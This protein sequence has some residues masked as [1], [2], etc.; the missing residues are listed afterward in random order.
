M[1]LPVASLIQDRRQ[2]DEL[3]NA[4]LNRR[5]QLIQF[6]R[7]LSLRQDYWANMYTLLDVLQQSK[8]LGVARRFVSNEPRTGFDAALSI[9]TRNPIPWRIPLLGSDEENQEERRNIGRVERSLEGIVYDLDELFGMR[10]QMPFWKQVGFQGLLRGMIWGKVQ[11]STEALQYRR[12]PLVGEIYDSRMVY[13]HFDQWGLNHIIIEKPTNLGDMVASYPGAWGDMEGNAAYD[14]NTAALRLEYWSNDRGDKKG[15][16]AV[17]GSVGTPVSTSAFTGMTVG[18]TVSKDSRW[19]IPP[20]F[21]GYSYDD[22]PVVGVPVNGAHIAHKPAV[23]S[24]IEQRL[25][26]R[27]D[28]LA[29]ESLAWYGPSSWV[30]EMGRG[31][32]SA[33]EEQVP[34]YNELIATIFQHFTMETYPTW[35][36]KTPTGELPEFT[37]GI[38][39]HIPLTPQDAVERLVPTPIS[40]DA[41]RL[42]SILQEERQKGILSNILQAQMPFS[43][44]GVLH[45]Q[46]THAALNSIEPYYSGMQQFGI[47]M[48]TSLLGQLKRAAP[49]LAPFELQSMTPKKTYFRIEFNPLTDLDQNRHYRPVPFIKPAL[50][51]DLTVRMT[52]ARM[53]LDPRRPMMSLIT[54]L[55]D[56]LQVDDPAAEA[57]RIWFDLAEQDP[58]LILEH[59]AQALERHGEMEM[60]ARIRQNEFATKFV[61]D[62]RIRQ[63]T[64]NTPGREGF[65]VPG[66]EAGPLALST[67]RTGTEQ[68]LPPEMAAAGA[69]GMTAGV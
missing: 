18:E 64:G 69:M 46:V 13:P 53:A 50:P 12:S 27:A 67:Q 66:P 5:R 23:L 47:R 9:L 8:P 58:V 30:A 11:V 61:E 37:P 38:G 26:E 44:T 20:Y 60:A 31:I 55:E 33:V 51:D 63:L 49:I 24:P 7:P 41:Y 16:H 21:H 56:I 43:G 62:M 6:W 4:L 3:K 65:Q 2:L 1:A 45:Q 48:G 57:D 42:V 35:V 25:Q 22:L 39:A 68:N 14:Q 28:L 36:F 29:M 32:L 10:G 54:V 40:P 15:I 19:L 52:A 17:L 59:M 34:Q